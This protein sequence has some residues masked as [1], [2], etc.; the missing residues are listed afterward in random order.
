MPYA[1]R[2]AVPGTRALCGT[3]WRARR[4]KLGQLESSP[5]W[6]GALRP[7]PGPR[8]DELLTLDPEA[9]VAPIMMS[10]PPEKM[11][12]IAVALN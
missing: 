9:I 1:P 8:V 3:C 12:R 7:L 4:A 2:V 11:D 6:L 5:T 10:V